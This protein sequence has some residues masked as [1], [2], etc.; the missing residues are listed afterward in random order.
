MQFVVISLV[1]LP[2]L[3]NRFYGPYGVLNPF[4]I[5][6]MVVF[7][8]GISLTGYVI[9]KL[10][11]HRAGA[12]AGGV[13]GGLISST[14]TTASF[15]RRVRETPG[16]RGIATLVIVLASTIALGRVLLIVSVRGPAFLPSV[17][18]PLG[19]VLG[20][21]AAFSL[22]TWM[23][24]KRQ[25]AEVTE[26]K[27]PCELPAALLFGALYAL[28]LLAVAFAKEHLGQRGVYSVAVLSG[29]TDMDAITL[30][31]TELVTDGKIATDAG[32]R[33]ILAAALSNMAFKS[34]I[35][36]VLGG[37]RLFV[38]VGLVFGS[39]VGAGMVILAVAK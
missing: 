22:T 6:V 19:I 10:W 36:G 1:I 39:A 32:W 29:L 16:Q 18:L 12:L 8:V 34:G 37:W 38:R 11:G 25:A 21:L 26:P 14:A 35:A 13:L 9:F 23:L 3:P 7:I 33:A 27:N 15:S 30:S 24:T 20:V 4:H 17:L 2:V 31:V 5:W 28:V